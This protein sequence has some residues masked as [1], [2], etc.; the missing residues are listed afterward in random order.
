[1]RYLAIGDIHIDETNRLEDLKK[2][3]YQIADIAEQKE[4]DK[5]LFL[6]DLFTSR[7]PTALEYKTAYEWVMKLVDQASENSAPHRR[8]VLMAGNHDEQKDATTLDAFDILDVE[9]VSVVKTN[10]IEDTIFMG[11]FLLK[12]LLGNDNIPSDKLV[13]AEQLV[14]R[15]PT[16][17]LFLLGDNHTPGQYQFG[18]KMFYSLGSIDRNNFGERKNEPRVLL[19]DASI[20]P[21]SIP[22]IK[23]ESI[24]LKVR[25]MIQCNLT[26][27]DCLSTALS[28]MPHNFSEAIVKAVIKGSEEDLKKIDMQVLRDFF[29][30][31]KSLVIQFDVERKEIVR[32]L[33]MKEDA[34]EESAL[35]HFLLTKRED[36]NDKSKNNILVKGKEII[37]K[38]KEKK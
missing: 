13:T 30:S 18:D 7:R 38:V 21:D 33:E 32:D 25:P 34:D 14:A 16:S 26:A 9:G 12:E 10:H 31:A 8:V 27:E 6:G 5:I 1:M 17:S 23:I 22:H 2:V 3:L 29:K 4:V 20:L 15:Y 35:T 19:F 24:P 37:Q 36:L 11:H 28:L